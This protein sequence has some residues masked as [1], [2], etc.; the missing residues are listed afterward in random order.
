MT[1]P[2]LLYGAMLLRRQFLC[3][4]TLFGLLLCTCLIRLSST[5]IFYGG[6]E[7]SLA[8]HRLDIVVP[9]QSE[10]EKHGAFVAAAVPGRSGAGE[11]KS[12]GYLL[13]VEY[14]Q[15][16]MG[17][18]MGL[19]HLAYITSLLN[20]SSVEPFVRRTKLE[21]APL[22]RKDPEPQV[23]KLSSF[24]DLDHLKHSVR[25][26]C[27]NNSLVS[28]ETFMEGASQDVVVVR[29]LISLEKYEHYF[30]NGNKIIE[31]RD[32]NGSLSSMCID[33]LNNWVEW[34]AKENSWTPEIFRVSSVVL[35]DARPHHPLPLEKL[36]QKLGSIVRW[37]VAKFGTAT[38]VLDNWR[39]IEI[40]RRTRAFYLISGFKW[41]Y[42]HNLDTSRLSQSVVSAAKEFGEG[43]LNQTRPVIG[44]HIRAEKLLMNLNGSIP[45]YRHCL[46]QLRRIINK[47]TVGRR[48][49]IGSMFLFHDLGKYGTKSCTFGYCQQRKD[50]FLLD[51]EGFGYKTVHFDPVQFRPTGLQ[52][53]YAAFVEME[54]LSN[55]D[56]LIVV[57]AGEW[58]EHIVKR[59]VNNRGENNLHRI[60]HTESLQSTKST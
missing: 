20:L 27:R 12:K 59:F 24:F 18:F 13:A 36:V 38:L 19:Y 37:Q 39:D 30:S 6:S 45:H 40:D 60:C 46:M 8:D 28:F 53:A 11:S 47:E 5:P 3:A 25:S 16:L 14:K 2:W 29:F 7:S 35:I 57:G 26:C 22:I 56:I 48:S 51:L 44:I 17:A 50:L 4:V 49:L 54:Y 31:V 41:K 10:R 33:D 9:P 32:G 58:Q 15:Q 34:G 21:G 43:Q 52:S 23:V 1:D 42:C 55:V